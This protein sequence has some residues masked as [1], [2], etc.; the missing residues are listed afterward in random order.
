MSH[1]E[2]NR[3]VLTRRAFLTNA[4]GFT[5]TL[6]AG[7]AWQVPARALARAP[8][9]YGS[10]VW[11]AGDHH[12]HTRYSPDGQYLIAQQVAQAA[13][14]GLHWCVITDHGGPSHDKIA[15]EQ[16]YPELLAAR[17]AHP[18]VTVFQGLEWNI[19]DAEHGSVILPP[20]ADE[21]RSIARFEAQFD[22][23][24]QSLADTPANREADAVAGLKYLQS[25]RPRPLFFANHPARNGL[26]SPHEMRA[27]AEAAPDVARGFEGAPGH[28]AATIVGERRGAYGASP[29]ASSWPGYPPESYRTWGGYD[30]YVA[31]V[32][33]LWD[34][35]LGEGRAWFITANS[36]SHR[37]FTDRT[38]VD[39]STYATLGHTT[40]TDKEVG[41][42]QNEDFFPG[43]YAKTW[44]YARSR[45]PE[46][47]LEAMR[48]G[49]MF[50]AM[51]NLVDAVELSARSGD[52]VAAMGGT[53]QCEQSGQ[54]VLVS[55]RVR[56]PS[57]PNRNG[58]RPALHHIDL[59]AGDIL[60]LAADR[61][62]MTNPTT[63]VVARLLP[64]EA[65]REGQ[66]LTFQHRFAKVRKSFYVRARGTNTDV[67]APRMDPLVLDP[68]DDLWFY[69]NP[70]FV[71]VPAQRR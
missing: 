15:L 25:I 36:D 14:H 51:G 27:W 12:I 24:N 1:D 26:D 5:L 6:G 45:A 33:G 10:G 69:S 56:V 55:L 59:I 37:H 9:P 4:A 34:S 54:D 18:N 52:R 3:Q 32:G 46:A 63:R 21:A 53:L 31:K 61:D 23:K 50:T 16:A 49:N 44:V 43:E 11:Q 40:P 67:E 64:R 20:H 29:R 66:F 47:V 17:R 48:A 7:S 35:L 42:M 22:E 41:Q 38:V 19:P 30:W 8:Y 13:R 57:R 71:R 28:G 62:A 2:L 70:V 68:W 39:G 60:G 58:I 65:R